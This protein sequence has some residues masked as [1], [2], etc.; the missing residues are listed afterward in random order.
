MLCASRK[1][2]TIVWTMERYQRGRM[3]KG[4]VIGPD[5]ETRAVV[6]IAVRPC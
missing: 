1:R 5:V 6:K 3:T 4:E 2:F